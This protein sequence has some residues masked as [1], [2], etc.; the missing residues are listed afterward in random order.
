M[1]ATTGWRRL[2]SVSVPLLAAG[3]AAGALCGTLI[4]GTGARLAMRAVALLG[5]QEPGFTVGGTVFI[6]ILG[7]LFGALLGM[8]YGMLRGLL[9]VKGVLAG[10][11]FG[12]ASALLLVVLPV[13]RLGPEGELALATPQV[14]IA[15]FGGL[16]AGFGAA[17]GATADVLARRQSVASDRRVNVLW[18]VALLVATL[19]FISQ[20]SSL[21]TEFQPIPLFFS[22]LMGERGLGFMQI[23]EFHSGLV[24]LFALAY[25]ALSLG[26]LAAGRGDRPARWSALALLLIGGLLLHAGRAPAIIPHTMAIWAAGV[27][28]LF[29]ALGFGA[30]VGLLYVTPDGH[31]RSRGWRATWLAWCAWFLVWLLPLFPGT[32]L[33]VMQWPAVWRV[34]PVLLALGSGLAAI[35][36]RLR[37]AP[38]GERGALWLAL[39]GYGAMLFG[40]GLIWLAIPTVDGWLAGR[41]MGVTNWF[42]FGGFLLPWLLLPG[43]TLAVQWRRARSGDGERIEKSGELAAV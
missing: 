15:L 37:E 27:P 14:T 43:V 41:A 11:A 24:L 33:D 32:A 40:L 42:G 23:R 26:V 16:L 36:L 9:R 4:L 17:M 35:G 18:P 21:G 2:T 10:L 30:V 19:F 3:T 13:I 25:W 38:A 39:A 28:R 34:L 12:L 6:M 1:S 31:F 5:G 20:V 29:Q 8:L 22:K 7:G